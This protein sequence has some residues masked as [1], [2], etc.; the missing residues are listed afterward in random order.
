MIAFAV[1]MN[2]F[3]LLSLDIT[4]YALQMQ[5]VRSFSVFINT[6]GKKE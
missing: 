4:I 2:I 6:H 3:S 1:G 5:M